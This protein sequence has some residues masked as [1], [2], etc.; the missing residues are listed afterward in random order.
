M[1][2]GSA[3]WSAITSTSLGPASMSMRTR[4]CTWRLASATYWLPGPTITSTRGMVAVPK[5]S[6]PM[7]QAEPAL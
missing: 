2:A 3:V 6:A 1:K 4:P 5:A 7:A